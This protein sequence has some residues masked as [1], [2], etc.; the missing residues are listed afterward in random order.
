VPH[1]GVLAHGVSRPVR[2]V[3]M[4]RVRAI[5]GGPQLLAGREIVMP[6]IVLAATATA[7]ATATG[8]LRAV[9]PLAS[10]ITASASATGTLFEPIPLDGVLA[11]GTLRPVRVATPRLARTVRGGP[12]LLAGR[13]TAAPGADLAANVTGAATTA[14]VLSVAKPLTASISATASSDGTLAGSAAPLASSVTGAASVTAVLTVAK[15]LAASITGA[16]AGAGTLTGAAQSLTASVSAVASVTGILSVAKPL[17][18][19]VTAVATTTAILGPIPPGTSGLLCPDLSLGQRLTPAVALAP[20][21][22]H[23]AALTLTPGGT[24]ALQPRLTPV[25]T[26][27]SRC[28]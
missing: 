11:R 8:T 23:V 5:R 9:H 12:Q 24:V 4:R 20:A 10:A 19:T 2:V 1:D 25:V 3:D 21:D 28:D 27:R 14:A 16:A 13:Q 18:A 22:A 7:N 15:P 6:P 17:T 26:L